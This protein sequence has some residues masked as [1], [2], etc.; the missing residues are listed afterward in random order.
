M[1]LLNAAS[2]LCLVALASA[3]KGGKGEVDPE[4]LNPDVDAVGAKSPEFVEG[5][6]S[7]FMW[8]SLEK[9]KWVHAVVLNG[10]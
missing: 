10:L 6:F 4:V 5:S 3:K 1:H 2:I 7:V 9:T 8:I